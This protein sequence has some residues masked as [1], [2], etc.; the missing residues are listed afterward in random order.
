MLRQKSPDAAE[1]Y[2]AA[3]NR[4]SVRIIVQYRTPQGPARA[5]LGTAA[6]NIPAIVAE[7]HAAQDTILSSDVGPPGQLSG[8][9]TALRRFDITA[10]FAINATAAQIE[11]LAQDDRVVS[12]TMDRAFPPQLIQS[13]P[14]IGMPSA[15]NAGATGNGW[16]VAVV[17]TGVDQTHQFLAGK[18]IAQACFSTTQGT[19][20]NGGSLSLCPPSPQTIVA[21]PNR[22]GFQTG[23]VAATNLLVGGGAP[24][25]GYT[26]SSSNLPPGLVLNAATGVISGNG[27]PAS[28][29]PA[30]STIDIPITVTDGTQ[31]IPAPPGTVTFSVQDYPPGN[32]NICGLPIFQV[33]AGPIPLYAQP[34]APYGVT[35]SVVGGTPP[36]TWTLAKNS[37]L[38]AGLV[39]GPSTGVVHGTASQSQAG[40]TFNFSITV[41]DSTNGSA[42]VSGPYSITV[43]GNGITCPGTA[44]QFFGTAN[45]G[46]GANCS[47]NGCE[48]GTHV[49]GIA[50][51]L[52][53]QF[54]TGQP[55]NGVAKS[56]SLI[57][58]QTYSEFTGAG[59]NNCGNAAS[60]C[61]L[62]LN[63]DIAA[64]LNY[65]YSIRNSLPGGTQLAAANFS[66]GGGLYSG[67][68]DTAVD[69]GAVASAI[70]LLSSAG[71]ATTVSA[72]NG[73]AGQNGS[74]SQI[75]WPAC[76]SSAIAVASS[77]KVDVVSSFS[78]LSSQ[79][80]VF[81]PGGETNP[82]PPPCTTAGICPILSSFPPNFACSNYSG[83]GNYCGDSGT[84]MAA[85]H[86]AGAIAAM[87]TVCPASTV[88]Q[89]LDALIK[90][91]TPITDH[92]QGGTVTK[93][94]IRVNLALRNGCKGIAWNDTHQFTGDGNSDLP[95][96]NTSGAVALWLMNGSS[97]LSSGGF[98][99][100][101]TTYSI[102]GQRDFT[103]GGDADMLWRDSS[104]NLY[105]WL[106]NGLTV[107]STA[108]LGNV[109]TNWTVYGTGDLNRDGIGDLL[110][111]D[112][113]GNVAIWFMN[114]SQI[115]STT[116][117]G[118]VPT[119]WTIVGD[120]NRGD[121]LWRDNSGD[122]AIWQM[123]GSQ[124]VDAA[125]GLG[126]VPSNWVIAG[127]GDFNGDG[128]LDILWRDNNS[129]TVAIWFLNG[130]EQIQST[131][132]LGAVPSTWKIA[133][134]GDYNGDGKSDILW[135]DNSGNVAIWFMNGP[136]ISSTAGY[137]NVGTSWLVQSLNA[138]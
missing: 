111:R 60:P 114:G 78:D 74:T 11:A 99:T 61:V 51:G 1:M 75:S 132:S 33:F 9:G 108:G 97:V 68:C 116:S 54:Q 64:S 56:A 65:V 72:G 70:N 85:P 24:S 16:V 119:N 49:A 90:S 117:L 14:L 8:A 113:S 131:A 80:A 122:L 62:A 10:G 5:N 53:S 84:S 42:Y 92:R 36:Y 86:V 48:H 93:N 26:W 37:V 82:P 120:D 129:G 7:N 30:N 13:V 138:E 107:S 6:E 135:I 87:R 45:A 18:T 4:G 25:S 59:A 32:T 3:Q 43:C 76:I 136:T 12:I 127:V 46:P 103:G 73:P 67:T 95:W 44:L 28:I 130:S 22:P 17:D 77:S 40:Q 101:A 23:A 96:R 110:W 106:M 109:P 29:P 52:N 34:G 71:I 66:G 69:N 115:A 125:V 81:A 15:Y 123:N 35:L 20:G 31:T 105:M 55:P 79:V 63:S 19:L 124:G 88:Q 102:I 133:E 47:I 89:I 27:N 41:T 128:Y 134:T 126:N 21:C 58:I 83:P 121:I 91:G 118:Q 94:R 100:I 2:A 98:G 137:G 104:G 39:L 57:A 50:V 38:P 112:S